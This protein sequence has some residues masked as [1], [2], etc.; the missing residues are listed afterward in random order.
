MVK[1]LNLKENWAHFACVLIGAMIVFI[2]IQ[3][4]TS[5][6]IYGGSYRAVKFGG[7][8][9]TEIHEV[10]T[11]AVNTLRKIYDM[12]RI[13]MG[14]CMIGGGLTEMIVSIRKLRFCKCEENNVACA[15]AETLKEEN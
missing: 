9:Y 7:D 5:Y 6:D 8:F 2:G 12:L 10:T 1:K 11:S 4:L 13:G 14:W 3:F 15:C